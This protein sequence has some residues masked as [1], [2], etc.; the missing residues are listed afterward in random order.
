MKKIYFLVLIA[1]SFNA[2]AQVTVSIKTGLSLSSDIIPAQNSTSTFQPTSMKAGFYGGLVIQVPVAPR[3]SIVPELLY[4]QKGYHERSYLVP[5]AFPPH[6]NQSYNLTYSFLDVPV[7][8]DLKVSKKTAIQFG[9]Q[10]SFMLSGKQQLTGPDFFDSFDM[11][12][13]PKIIFGLA[14]GMYTHVWKLVSVS[15]HYSIDLQTHDEDEDINHNFLLHGF[16]NQTLQVGVMY[17][18]AHRK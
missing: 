3:F 16:R 17:T 7:L 11:E 12:S 1:A 8:A 10:V 18:L 15:L 6:T 2:G 13:S 5:N 14:A 9:P 4:S